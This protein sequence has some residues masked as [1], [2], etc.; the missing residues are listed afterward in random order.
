MKR[1]RKREKNK[2]DHFYDHRGALKN[3]NNNNN[4]DNTDTLTVG[5]KFF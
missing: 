5:G 3:M 1:E 2:L 4:F